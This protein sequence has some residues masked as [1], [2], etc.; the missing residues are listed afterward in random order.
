MMGNRQDFDAVVIGAGHAGVEAA[1]ALGRR[2]FR[3]ALISFDR[4]K[5][6]A[7]SCNP[8][9]GGVAKSHLVFEVDALGGL[10]GQCAD[11]ASIQSKRLNLKKGPAVRSTRSQCDKDFYARTMSAWMS[12]YP[13]V[14]LVEAEVAGFHW[15]GDKRIESVS[16]KDGSIMRTRCVVLTAGTFMRAVM[17]M[18]S[19][20]SSGGRLGDRAASTL[21]QS[22]EETGHSLTRLKTGTPARLDSR[23]IDF[24][25]LEKQ[26]GDPERRR[27]SWKKPKTTL[28]QVCCHMTYTNERTH[29]VI[30]ANF[31]RSALFSGEIQGVGPRYCPSVE[32][33]IKRFPERPRHQVFLEPEGIATPLVY[34]NGMS[35]SLPLDV[36]LEFLRTMEGLENVELLKPGY[37]VEYDCLD[38]TELN[39]SFMS[40]NIEGLFTAGQVNRTSGYEEAASQGLW[41]G[42]QASLWLEEAEFLKPDRSRS[43]MET[44]VDDLTTVGSLEPYRMFTSRSEY[45]LNLREDNAPERMHDLG[46]AL[47]LLSTEQIVDYNAMRGSLASETASLGLKRVRLDKDRV[48]SV[49]DVLKRPEVSW[50]SLELAELDGC[51]ERVLERIEVDA[52]YSGYLK[53]QEAEIKELRIAR[54]LLLDPDV[55]LRGLSGLS[56]EVIEKFEAHRPESVFELSR[57]SGI[58]PAA[59]LLISR[60]AGRRSVGDVSRET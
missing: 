7:M 19:E 46:L 52:K 9:I 42:I 16:L 17:F 18:G 8:A 40:K 43:Y 58:T 37:A 5:V 14:E 1:A 50:E 55:S 6:G 2:G 3:T 38:P 57:I 21:S 48:V 44:L 54:E 31:H 49:L 11:L 13:N 32:D 23:S 34:P 47:G 41:A 20:R 56:E 39:Y 60:A 59:V 36:Q 4:L 35:T 51:D 53:K 12:D 30:R 26:W 45:R 29:E 10:M 28:P 25:K 27:F 22:I 24:S 15:S 33:K